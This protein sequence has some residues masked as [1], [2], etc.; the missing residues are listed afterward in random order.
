MP[1][2]PVA[3]ALT[4]LAVAVGVALLCPW[5]GARGF[6]RNLM[7]CVLGVVLLM[8]VGAVAGTVLRDFLLEMS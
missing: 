2:H 1:S 3:V 5:T 6:V 4:V 7:V 8:A